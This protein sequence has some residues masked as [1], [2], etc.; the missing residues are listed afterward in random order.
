[1]PQA[2][3]TIIDLPHRRVFS[4]L[5]LHAVAIGSIAAA[6][7]LGGWGFGLGFLKT[8][9]PGLPAMQP[10]TA[11]AFMLLSL[12]CLTSLRG[13]PGGQKVSV[14][15]SVTVL[16]MALAAGLFLPSGPGAQPWAER[17]GPATLAGIALSAT[18]MGLTVASPRAAV[19]VGVMA[20]CGI[21]PA[22]FRFASLTVFGGAPEGAG[23]GFTRGLAL[24][25]AILE[26]WFMTACVLMH[27]RLPFSTAVLQ[28]GLRGRVLRRA[29][30]AMIIVPAVGGVTGFILARGLGW[31][32]G[33]L[34]G[35]SV[36]LSVTLG[37]IL[38]WWISGLVQQWQIE[39]NEHATRLTR[40]NEALDQ[41][42]GAAAHDLKA[43]ARH[44]L[45]Y[46]E[47][48]EDAQKRGDMDSVRKFTGSIREAAAELPV[49]IDGMLEYSR[50]AWTRLN[51]GQH[52]LSELVGAAA[53]LQGEVMKAERA[54][55]SVVREAV[56][57]CDPILMTAVFQ[58]LFANSLKNGRPGQPVK[59]RVD[60]ERQADRWRMT[61]EDNGVGFPQ[62]H[63][64][65]AFN[66]LVRGA[67]LAGTG[68]GIGL[69][70]CR[71]IIQSHRGDIR[72]DPDYREGARIVFTLAAEPPPADEKPHAETHRR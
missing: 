1:M 11:I 31:P 37:V 64:A 28:P 69:A 43:P 58:N 26:I 9:A 63:A 13:S 56:I 27:P 49:V 41:F 54:Q 38:I 25:G 48:L 72:V 33:V 36:T 19:L 18:A 30:P 15:L 12:A 68:T 2:V 5:E 6:V 35:V 20:L 62:A 66:P 55:V 52:S 4:A 57:L 50:S 40:A 21:T 8:V 29:L 61:V 46:S 53:Q 7:L 10:L 47:L 70:T 34:F 3:D 51:L 67:H 60:A 17:P 22:L 16:A 32:P 42:A 65:V 14:A 59:I 24:H 45:L 39:A 71:T 23:P 44:I